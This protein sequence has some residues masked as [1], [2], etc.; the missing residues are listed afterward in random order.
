VQEPALKR[1]RNNDG[2]DSGEDSDAYLFKEEENENE[3]DPKSEIVKQEIEI[4]NPK[5]EVETQP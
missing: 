3:T 2:S 4:S 5:V 1:A